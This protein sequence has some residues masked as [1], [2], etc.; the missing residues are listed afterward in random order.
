MSLARRSE[1]ILDTEMQLDAPRTKPGA[2]PLCQGGR[3]VDLDHLE[4]ADVEVP[5]G[6]LLP[7]WH[8]Q[9]HMVHAL[10][11]H[12]AFF[13]TVTLAGSTSGPV[14]NVRGESSSR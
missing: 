6:V 13:V 14:V 11:G 1:V 5:G 10:E 9:L 12:A 7:R 8:G 2:A 4:D 3:L